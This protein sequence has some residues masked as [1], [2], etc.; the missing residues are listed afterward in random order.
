M[1][2][3]FNFLRLSLQLLRNSKCDLNLNCVNGVYEPVDC[4]SRHTK[5]FDLYRNSSIYSRCSI[6]FKI[7]DGATPPIIEYQIMDAG[8]TVCDLPALPAD[9]LVCL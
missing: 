6:V 4:N 8:N 1:K 3:L 5:H 7:I 9:E 2:N